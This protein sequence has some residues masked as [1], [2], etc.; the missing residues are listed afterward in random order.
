MQGKSVKESLQKRVSRNSWYDCLSF[1]KNKRISYTQ[2]I[3][4]EKNNIYLADEQYCT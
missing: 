3:D 1:V 4:G 2:Q